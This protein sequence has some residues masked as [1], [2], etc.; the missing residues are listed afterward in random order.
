MT[1]EVNGKKV[2][3]K[4][5]ILTM[6]DFCKRRGCNF[7]DY[8]KQFTN[9]PTG[10]V[11]DLLVCANNVH[12]K[13]NGMNVYEMDEL[14]EAMTNDQLQEVMNEHSAGFVSFVD[15]FSGSKKK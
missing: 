7:S 15:K 9:D 6:T 3:F 1:I 12:E 14:I 11:L 5:T 4:F 10:A 13:G 8:D 2:G